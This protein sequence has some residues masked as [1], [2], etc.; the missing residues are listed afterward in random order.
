MLF[1]GCRPA[2]QSPTFN[3]VDITGAGYARELALRDPSG[4][5][6]TLAEFRGKLVLVFFGYARCPDICPTTLADMA[7]VK[8]R[9]GKDGDRLQ[10]IFVTVDP[11]R[12]TPQVLA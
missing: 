1:A 9:L 5:Q 6:R 7:E 8:R 4:A 3:G 11:E 10:V 2:G 12:D